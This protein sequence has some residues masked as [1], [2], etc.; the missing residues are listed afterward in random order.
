MR[1]TLLRLSFSLTAAL[2]WSA[3]GART[4]F[5]EPRDASP[6]AASD[7]TP[8][9]DT[10]PAVDV[11]VD[12]TPVVDVIVDTGPACVEGLP[13]TDGVG[14]C[15]IGRT[16]CAGAMQLCLPAGNQLPGTTCMGGTCDGRGACRSGE[17]RSCPTASET[18][19]G[20][21][22][23]T[24]GT[25]SLGDASGY[26]AQPPQPAITVGG[27]S[28]DAY[29]VTVSRFQRF[30]A[31]G[32]PAPPGAAVAYPDGTMR[33]SGAVNE[34]TNPPMGTERC[35][36][37]QMGREYHPLN[38]VDWA[39]AQ[40]FCVW[41]GGRLPTEAEWEY[42]ARYAPAAGLSPGRLYPWGAEVPSAMCDRAQWSR[43]AGDDG[44]ATRRVGAFNNTAGFFDLAGNVWEWTADLFAPYANTQCWNRVAR[45]NPRC[46]V[47]DT[48][49]PTIRGGSWYS[50]ER[51]LLQGSAR[52]DAYRP[53]TRSAL[54]GF[55]CA[56]TR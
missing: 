36:W 15:V 33:W 20:L 50:P 19:C 44:A 40:A 2:V 24:G 16:R 34:P 47:N 43:C 45:T 17:Q 5:R 54:L 42:A 14:D 52:D 48:G 22:Y 3:C 35:N 31:A 13:C 10:T 32:H 51:V 39:T 8:V 4:P 30:W 6:D 18:G 7:T 23:L 9:I 37:G 21:V 12:E 53:D 46:P 49:Y 1:P 11:V 38:C 55:R 41:D 25:F 26:R 28:L 29:E 56:R 27:F